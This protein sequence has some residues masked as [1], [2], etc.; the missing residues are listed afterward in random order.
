MAKTDIQR[1]LGVL[2][3]NKP[4]EIIL[5]VDKK[6]RGGKKT[7]DVKDTIKTG[8]ALVGLVVIGAHGLNI[9]LAKLLKAENPMIN[10]SNA[11]AHVHSRID[12]FCRNPVKILNDKESCED[13][14]RK[15]RQLGFYAADAD[16]TPEQ[17]AQAQ[18]SF[19]KRGVSQK[20]DHASWESQAEAATVPGKY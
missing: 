1:H 14:W 5:Q 12:K 17:Y 6:P 11:E 20:S 4:E 18:E 10:V 2:Y 7:M 3:P 13:A 15:Y 8:F 19:R 9:G 16:V